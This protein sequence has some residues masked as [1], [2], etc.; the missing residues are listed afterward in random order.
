MKD[1][2]IREKFLSSD[3][4][5]ELI[6]LSETKGYSEADISYNTGARMN[7]EYRDNYRCLYRDESLR[8]QLES[9]VLDLAPKQVN[10]IQEGGVLVKKDLLGLSGNFRFYKYL[11]GNKFKKHRDG[12]QLEEGGVSLFTVLFYLNDVEEG[13]ETAVYDPSLENR[14]LVKAEE[15]KLLIFNHTIAHTGEEVT[16]GIKYILRTDLIYKV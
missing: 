9:L 14:I 10:F 12:N 11:P 13:G 4:C 15:G 8:L 3:F 2:I 7:K 16:K 1:Y 5:Q 6:M